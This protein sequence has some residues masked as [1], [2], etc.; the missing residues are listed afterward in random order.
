VEVKRSVELRSDLVVLIVAIVAPAW[1]AAIWVA[2]QPAPPTLPPALSLP[3][4]AVRNAIADDRRLARTAPPEHDENE[5]RRR[6]AY[7]ALG[8]A[9]LHG[10]S[11][12]SARLRRAE[13]AE[14]LAAIAARYGERAIA[15]VR[16][17]DVERAIR[18]LAGELPPTQRGEELG[19]LGQMLE[20]WGAV[21][22]GRRRADELVI[23][24]LAA[25]RWN[26]AHGRSPVDG[27]DRFRRQAYYGWL[28]LHGE[29][30]SE[31]MRAQALA[32][33][34]EAGGTDADEARGV[35]AWRRGD[36]EAAHAAF[37]RAHERTGS[38]RFRNH[39]LFVL[40][41]GASEGEGNP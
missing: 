33:Y 37:S 38:V 25:A 15:A 21:V 34:E 24:T 20:R 5:R 8:Q 3:A 1:L 19:R 4:E 10:G 40:A 26:I 39:A 2:P 32:A 16:A 13:M 23:R 9:E 6:E 12:D 30:A 7:R 18:A 14:A 31:T 28:A 22:G 35:F 36:V 29:A 11:E 17:R 27:F 41:A